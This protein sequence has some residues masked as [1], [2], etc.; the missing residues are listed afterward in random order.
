MTGA[1]VAFANLKAVGWVNAPL[2]PWGGF[3]LLAV[4]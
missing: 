3:E 1:G 4:F 2:T